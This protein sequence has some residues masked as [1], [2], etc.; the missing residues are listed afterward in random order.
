[1]VGDVEKT[2]L[3]L[4][5]DLQ[6]RLRAAAQSSRRP[7]AELVREALD[8]YLEERPSGRPRSV[9]M[10]SDGALGSG[11]AKGWVRSRWREE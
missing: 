2:T 9:G 3:Y 5:S 4:P 6:R 11:A 7:Q 8:A 10:G 1:M